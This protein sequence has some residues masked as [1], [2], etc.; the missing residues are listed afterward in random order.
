MPEFAAAF[1]QRAWVAR[2]VEPRD[3]PPV[4]SAVLSVVSA[5]PLVAWLALLA[6]LPDAL[7]A[8][9]EASA[10]PPDASVVPPVVLPAGLVVSRVASSGVAALLACAS[11]VCS[12]RLQLQG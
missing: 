9:P 7:D 1:G 5:A 10:A 6:A 11:L 12:L 4:A 3:A 2:R 8:P